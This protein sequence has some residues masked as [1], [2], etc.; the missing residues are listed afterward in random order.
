MDLHD[1]IH[2][3]DDLISNYDDEIAILMEMSANNGFALV[4]N[5]IQSE[6][7]A[8]KSYSTNKLPTYYFQ[9]KELN[10]GGRSLIVSAKKSGEGIDYKSWREANGLQTT[11]IDLSY[12]NRMWQDI[13]IIATF[14]TGDSYTVTVGG[15]DQETKD[16]LDWNTQRFGDF[17]ALDAKEEEIIKEMNEKGFNEIIEKYIK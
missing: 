1:A 12:T 14:K 10:A 8:G 6:G 13:G 16:K 7:I 11:F 5:R 9:D 17:L 2:A 3:F 15:K 4:S